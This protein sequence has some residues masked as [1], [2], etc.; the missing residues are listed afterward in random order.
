MYI[1]SQSH[2]SK[3]I[4]TSDIRKVTL[5]TSD[6]W[7][8]IKNEKLPRIVEANGSFRKVHFYRSRFFID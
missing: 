1:I 3:T 8:E 7:A 5:R 2:T 6:T 4:L